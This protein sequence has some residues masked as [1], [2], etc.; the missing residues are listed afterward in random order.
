VIDHGHVVAEGTPDG[1]KSRIGG[2][3]LEIVV[4]NPSDIGA[5]ASILDR[6]C[7]GDI[8]VDRDMRRLSTSTTSRVAD[9]IA[10]ARAMDDAGIALD[11]IAVRRPTLDEVFL[12][13]TENSRELTLSC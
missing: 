11:D 12:H 3:R 5:A 1:L 2:D 13:V 7:Q 4:H 8:Q 9:L 10:T 6:V